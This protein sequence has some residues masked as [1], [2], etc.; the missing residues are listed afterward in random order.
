MQEGRCPRGGDLSGKPLKLSLYPLSLLSTSDPDA[1]RC[2]QSV[3]QTLQKASDCFSL[4]ARQMD[5][6]RAMLRA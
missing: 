5:W 3:A 1:S 4:D 2:M 6:M